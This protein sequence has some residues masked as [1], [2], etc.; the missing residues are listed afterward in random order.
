MP[1]V[2]T[3]DLPSE[4]EVVLPMAVTNTP[5]PTATRTPT[6][7]PTATRTLTSTPYISGF[8]LVNSSLTRL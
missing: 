1:D 5:S 4:S 7:T 8:A 2:L 3:L 6:R